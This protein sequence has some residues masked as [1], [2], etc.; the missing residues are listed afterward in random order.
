MP[1]STLGRYSR[2]PVHS[3]RAIRTRLH[4][5]RN[6]DDHKAFQD[7]PNDMVEEKYKC[8]RFPDVEASPVAGIIKGCW[9]GTYGSADEVVT[10]LK[11]LQTE[12]T[13]ALN[14]TNVNKWTIFV[15]SPASS[16]PALSHYG[17][18]HMQL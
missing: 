7:D 1:I 3:S 17:L 2:K 13:V 16:Q 15:N 9:Y 4:H 8:Q 14:F 6:L 10:A 12:R 18:S 11:S 5:L